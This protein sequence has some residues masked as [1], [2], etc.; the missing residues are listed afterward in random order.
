ML[1][2]KYLFEQAFEV[3]DLLK[4]YVE[5]HNRCLKEAG[6]F[7]SLFKNTDFSDLLN[8]A[9]EISQKFDQKYAELNSFK[10]RNYELLHSVEKQFFNSLLEYVE[11]LSETN[12]KLV[13]LYEALYLR[14]I[15]KEGLSWLKYRSLGKKYEE[16]RKN[17]LT[18]GEKL[19]RNYHSLDVDFGVDNY[20]IKQNFSIQ[21]LFQMSF[22]VARKYQEQIDQMIFKVSKE[23]MAKFRFVRHSL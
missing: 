18:I 1:N 19:Q 7:L 21:D 15:N 11:A 20:S 14:S 9:K 17:Y 6:S 23:D 5:V 4:V 13:E 12:H 3:E 16:A 8:S 22:D 10:Q 2:K